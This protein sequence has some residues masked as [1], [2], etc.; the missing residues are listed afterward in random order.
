M[1]FEE[2]RKERWLKYP[3]RKNVYTILIKINVKP[4]DKYLDK[5]K[6]AQMKSKRR[7]KPWTLDFFWKVDVKKNVNTP[8]DNI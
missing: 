6:K 8:G 2:V 4:V 7:I 5:T 3:V 1:K